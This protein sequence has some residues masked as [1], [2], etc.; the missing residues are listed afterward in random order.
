M[1]EMYI[2]ADRLRRNFEIV[3]AFGTSYEIALVLLVGGLNGCLGS[4]NAYHFKLRR[5]DISFEINMLKTL[6]GCRC[7]VGTIGYT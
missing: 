7:I 6:Q 4:E 1:I 2:L 3:I 5:N